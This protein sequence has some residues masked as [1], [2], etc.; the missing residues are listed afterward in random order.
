M[1]ITLSER[2]WQRTLLFLS[3]H[4]RVYVADPSDCRVFLSACLW[5][6]RTGAQWRQLPEAYGKWNSVYRR[7]ARWAKVG[8]FDDM[9]SFFRSDSDKEWLC[10]DSSTIRAHM[11]AAAAPKSAGGQ[12]AQSLGRSRG[13]F[14][15]K[16][17]IQTDALG[18]PLKVVLTAGQR[19]DVIGYRMLREEEDLQSHVVWM[20]MGYDANWIREEWE[21]A[22]VEV[23]M[24]SHSSR[25]EAIPYDK[26][27]YEHRHVVECCINKLK[28]FRRVF[29]RYDKL[30]TSFLA[31]VQ[32]ASSLVWLR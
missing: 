15:S 11:S 29:T 6:L 20:D 5:I 2:Q 27:I 14:T 17:H 3:Q 1:S 25:R 7:F 18:N 19:H 30:D 32:F 23:V 21:K 4:P 22:Q 10:F 13:G 28:W 16:V 26:A 12:E 8:V 31:F 9:L 24:P